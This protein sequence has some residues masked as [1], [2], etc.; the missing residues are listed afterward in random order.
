M[1]PLQLKRFSRIFHA[2]LALTGIAYYNGVT[3]SPG[4][5]KDD[6]VEYGRWGREEH[7][8]R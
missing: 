7:A 4:F 2:L 3:T 6:W 5:V 1:D 8:M